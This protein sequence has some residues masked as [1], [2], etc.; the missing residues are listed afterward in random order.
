MAVK[1][2]SLYLLSVTLL[3]SLCWAQNYFATGKT[4][5]P[6]RSQ[7]LPNAKPP[8]YQRPGQKPSPPSHSQQPQKPIVQ[9]PEYATCEV[10]QPLKI[11]C[12]LNGIT[13]TECQ[14][15]NC[16]YDGQMCYYGNAVTLQCTKDG[17]FIVVIARDA[18]LP[19][20]DLDSINFMGSDPTCQTVGTTSAFAI[21]EFPVTAC[22]TTVTESEDNVITYENR[23]S[24]SYEVAVGPFGAITRDSQFDL[25]VQ[26][27]YTGTAV[28]ALVKEVSGLPPPLPPAAPGPLR[29][30]LRLGNGQCTTKGCVEA[31]VAYSSYYQE[32]DYPVTKVLRD[33]V[34]VEVRILERTDPNLVLTLGRCWGTSSP[35]PYS[36]PQWDLLV[37]GC[38]YRDDRYQ[39]ALVPVVGSPDVPFPTHY[40]RFIFKMFTFVAT[41][42]ADGTK[43]N[44]QDAI[45]TPLREMVYIHCNTAVCTPTAQDNCEPRCFRR[46]RDVAASV[47]GGFRQESSTVSSPL[48]IIVNQSDEEQ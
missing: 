43:K 5:N 4:Q 6:Q 33:P 35:N 38:P 13:E 12:G 20:I 11:R 9:Q 19:N 34:Y 2:F 24:S 17:R 14:S 47:M 46:R 16:C 42:S 37:D 21:Y 28:L 7:Y 45:L 23:M 15:I 8:Q 36:M 18:T 31:D 32:S 3:S 1:R 30:E 27:R 10:A 29:V 25:V 26:C 44:P 40:R 22:G 41:G 48:I 39:T